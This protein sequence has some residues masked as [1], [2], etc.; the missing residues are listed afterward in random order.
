MGD[1]N[2][3]DDIEEIA[4]NIINNG[5]TVEVGDYALLKLKNGYNVYKRVLFQNEDRII[6]N[7]ENPELY[8]KIIKNNTTL[9]EQEGEI[10]LSKNKLEKD[11]KCL[12]DPENTHK[13]YILKNKEIDDKIVQHY[14]LD[15]KSHKY[16]FKDIGKC[17]LG[18]FKRMEEDIK[19][20]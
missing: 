6:W 16:K 9:C 18:K 17:K 5:K 3:N 20:L 1:F 10:I 4:E 13:N 11:D 19:N 15:E 14:S 8:S 2:E 12:F 7:L